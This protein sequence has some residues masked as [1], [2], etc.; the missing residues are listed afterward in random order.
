MGKLCGN[1]VTSVEAMPHSAKKAL[2]QYQVSLS[3]ILA[4]F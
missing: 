4:G 2:H 1:D 3:L